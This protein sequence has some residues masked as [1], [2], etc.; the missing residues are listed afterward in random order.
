MAGDRYPDGRDPHVPT[1]PR[2]LILDPRDLPLLR[3]CLQQVPG[4]SFVITACNDVE[5]ALAAI[6]GRQ[7]DVILAEVHVTDEG[8]T[9]VLRMLR[10]VNCRAPVVMTGR[11]VDA[12]AAVDILRAGAA[13][14]VAK[15][16]LTPV[17]LHRA[18]QTAIERG[19]LE[20]RLAKHREL[21]E[22]EH[23]ALQQ[24]CGDLEAELDSLAGELAIVLAAVREF[25]ATI[26]PD[27]EWSP[28][29]RT[30]LRDALAGCAR[31]YGR[32]T[33]EVAAEPTFTGP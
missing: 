7:P 16:G 18:L 24:R 26:G 33:G 12:L 4:S 10:A 11:G 19:H 9:G 6:A 14:F 31:A 32:V 5:S 20:Q 29:Q 23:R 21:V 8:G 3:N 1:P 2:V 13:D 28:E 27:H 30:L 15:E 25:L 22:S 17:R